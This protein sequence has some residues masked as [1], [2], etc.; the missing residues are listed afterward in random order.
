MKKREINTLW[1]IREADDRLYC[2][3]SQPY[4]SYRSECKNDYEWMTEGEF[5]EINKKEFP[6]VKFTDPPLEVCIVEREYKL[7]EQ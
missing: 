5:I 1:V 3:N 4:R 6:Q 2:S 7:A